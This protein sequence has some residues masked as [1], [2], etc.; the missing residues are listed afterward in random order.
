MKFLKRVI[1]LDSRICCREAKPYMIMLVGG[2][3]GVSKR[4]GTEI[5]VFVGKDFKECIQIW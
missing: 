3:G 2:G 4:E 5:C 1:Y